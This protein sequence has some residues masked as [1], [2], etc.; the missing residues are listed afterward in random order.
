MWLSDHDI[1]RAMIQALESLQHMPNF[2]ELVSIRSDSNQILAHFS[3]MFGNPK[4]LRRLVEWEIDLTIANVNGLTALDC[5][6]RGGEKTVI[7]LLLNDGAPENVVGILGRIPAHLMPNEFEAS[8]IALGADGQ[9]PSDSMPRSSTRRGIKTRT[10]TWLGISTW[11]RSSMRSFST[12]APIPVMEHRTWTRN[13]RMT[14]SVCVRGG[15]I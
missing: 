11:R 7:E 9:A 1:E 6:Y 15:R 5:A 3:V 2:D 8:E 12:K 13:L 10:P 14:M 4:L